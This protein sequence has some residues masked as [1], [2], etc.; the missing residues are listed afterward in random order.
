MSTRVVVAFALVCVAV[1]LI[2]MIWQPVLG[3]LLLPMALLVAARS[4]YLHRRWVDAEGRKQHSRAQVKANQANIIYVQVVDDQGNDLPPAVARAKLE[5]AH[6]EAG[7]RDT[8]L[9]ARRKL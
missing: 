2:V 5:A 1:P 7:P 9:P 6:M 4:W 3:L 8:V